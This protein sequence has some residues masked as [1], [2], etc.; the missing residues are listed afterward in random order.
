[1][2]NIPKDDFDLYADHYR[3]LK[4]KGGVYRIYSKENKLLYV[5][6]TSDLYKRI[7]QHLHVHDPLVNPLVFVNH[8][9]YRV[10]GFYEDN[11]ELR[12]IYESYLINT[13]QPPCNRRNIDYKD[14]F[15]KYVHPDK[16]EAFMARYS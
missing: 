7:Y 1:M 4:H 15:I 9:F 5:G 14:N 8:H 12:K 10:K 16:L 3:G 13:L 6:M 11:S 2:I